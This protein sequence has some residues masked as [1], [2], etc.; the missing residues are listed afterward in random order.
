MYSSQINKRIAKKRLAAILMLISALAGFS[1]QRVDAHAKMLASKP[2]DRQTLMQIPKA[3]E[4]TF[5]ARLQPTE[6]NSIVVTDQNGTRVD[7]KTVVLSD[8]GRK[9]S[10]E[11]EEVGSGTFTVEWKA[12]SADDHPMNGK[13]S[14]IIAGKR[15][16][17]TATRETDN[18]KTIS[19][20]QTPAQKSGTSPF[21]SL[22][23]WF[24]YLAMMTLFGGFVFLLF[25]L[26]PALAPN[27][28]IGEKV[29][30]F[31]QSV[32]KFT[33]LTRLSLLIIIV[34]AFAS[35]VLQTSSL[36]DLSVAE[37]LAP[38]NLVRV[39]TGTGYGTPWFLQI[40]LTL[41]IFA[42][43][44]FFARRQ[45][46]DP[47]KDFSRGG[48]ALLWT[49][50]ILSAFLLLT[51]SLTGH[52]RAA[53]EEYKFAV[54]SDWLH[55]A[56]AG[57]WVG[58]IFQLALTLPKSVSGLPDLTR[59][60]V[61][62]RVI[63]RFSG[64]A[65]GCTILLALTGIYNS[66]IHLLGIRDLYNT[67]YGII[68]LVKIILFLL[69]LPLGGFNRFF[70]RPRVE[71]LVGDSNSDGLSGAEKDFRFV[72]YLETAFAATVLLLAAILA[73][74]PHSQEHHAAVRKS[75]IN[76]ERALLQAR[77]GEIRQP[78]SAFAGQI[79]RND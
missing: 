46:G 77:A 40:A 54:F 36:L 19:E 16:E 67:P 34:S 72:L 22:A 33:G 63:S 44:F 65:V 26:K 3:V 75:P 21:Q 70:I 30:A 79:E 27:L 6:M 37:A 8:D 14:F 1:A 68:L 12:L 76:A 59:L 61:L 7:K 53:Q 15:A 78:R 10:A 71:K 52:A 17:T 48:Q 5:S 57:V 24:S 73:F 38:A 41:A 35:L 13:F 11:L 64:L 62:S 43:T 9:M 18:I 49:G 60:A 39:L 23:R 28:I 56:A 58:G 2:S 32:K 66:W 29:P 31:G 4:L 55:L 20:N 42:I 50:L 74:L 45:N 25:V 69:M 47:V 51:L